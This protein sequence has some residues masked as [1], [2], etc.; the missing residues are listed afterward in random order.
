MKT[1]ERRGKDEEPAGGSGLDTRKEIGLFRKRTIKWLT[2]IKG[3]T[4]REN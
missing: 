1:R 4:W 3:M 2:P